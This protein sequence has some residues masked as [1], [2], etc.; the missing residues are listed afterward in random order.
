MTHGDRTA[1]RRLYPAQPN[2]S[3]S[4]PIDNSTEARRHQA[5]L[6]SQK[7]SYEP[8]GSLSPK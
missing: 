6:R 1:A 2:P 4:P 7:V 8:T 3:A 5:S